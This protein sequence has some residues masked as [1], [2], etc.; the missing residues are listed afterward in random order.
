[1]DTLPYTKLSKSLLHRA[2][3]NG[4]CKRNIW[5][6]IGGCPLGFWALHRLARAEDRLPTC[7]FWISDS[8]NPLSSALSHSYPGWNWSRW[9]FQGLSL[10][11]TTSHTNSS[12]CISKYIIA[13]SLT[14]SVDFADAS[15]LR[16]L[17]DCYCQIPYSCLWYLSTASLIPLK[18]LSAW[19]ASPFRQQHAMRFLNFGSARQFYDGSFSL[20]VTMEWWKKGKC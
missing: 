15:E 14:S 11:V 16:L 9:S 18:G 7:Q 13:M 8:L 1:M 12:T 4:T 5:G 17:T 2:R 19:V 20:Q 6:T 10:P 3:E